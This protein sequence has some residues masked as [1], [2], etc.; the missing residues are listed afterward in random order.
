MNLGSF[1]AALALGFVAGA[2]ARALIPNDAFR[3]MHGWRS[4]LT[5]AGLG[6]LGALVGFWIFHGLFGVG[7]TDKFVGW[8]R[9]RGDRRH[10]RCCP[11]VVPDQA[12]RQARGGLTW[13]GSV[14]PKGRSPAIHLFAACELGEDKL[15]R[16]IKPRKTPGP[17]P[18]FCRYLRSLYPPATR[19]AIICDNFSPHLTTDK[20]PRV[21]VRAKTANVEIACTPGEFVLVKTASRRSKLTALRYF[22]L[23]GTGH[24]SRRRGGQHDP[25]VHHLAQQ[26]RWCRISAR[27][28]RPARMP[29]RC[30]SR[31]PPRRDPG[32]AGHAAQQPT[33]RH[34]PDQLVPR[35]RRPPR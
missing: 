9:W 27:R 23:D 2:I 12:V 21:G 33:A 1:L 10:D 32:E 26:P 7:D 25:A 31:P 20:D 11:R 28:R 24:A 35:H 5:S 29:A 14:L 16:H 17:V 6:L 13:Y 8:H 3:H 34:R 30:R 15:Y 22:A 4:W 18:G 19:I